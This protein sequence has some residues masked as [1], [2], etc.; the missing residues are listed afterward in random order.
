MTSED[1]KTVVLNFLEA[2]E[3]NDFA[4]LGDQ[5]GR[6]QVLER[7]PMMRASFPDRTHKVDHQIAEG[8]TAATRV[9]MTGTHLGAFMGVEPTLGLLPQPPRPTKPGPPS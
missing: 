2:L 5:P 4:S 8:D 6:E 3:G 9:T 1:N 7:H